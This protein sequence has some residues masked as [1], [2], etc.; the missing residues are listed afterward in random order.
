M[1]H[2]S[3]ADIKSTIVSKMA[4]ISGRATPRNLQRV[5]VLQ[6][7]IRNERAKTWDQI[8]KIWFDETKAI[9]KS[10]PITMQ[11]TMKTVVPTKVEVA[12]P[13]VSQ[14][15]TL[16]TH[17]PFQGRVLKQWADGIRKKD[18][19]RIHDQITI[20][21]TQG[22]SNVAIA[23]RVVGTVGLRGANGVTQITRNDALAITRT[24]V[25]SFA[26][27][28]R[29]LFFEANKDA[30]KKERYVATLDNRTTAI[31][32]SLD[33]TV[34]NV[35]DGP[36]PPLHFQCRSIRVAILDKGFVSFRP[37]KPT[38]ERELVGKFAARNNLGIIT[39]RS[40]LPYGYKGRYDSFAKTEI[41]KLTGTV[42]AK[43]T[44]GSWLAKQSKV[45]Q[46][47]VLGVTKARLFRDGHLSLDKYVDR[48]GNE[49]TLS[50]LA[51]KEAQAFKAAGLDP[52]EFY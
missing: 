4:L 2:K 34:Y 27:R 42:P 33:G 13:A 5:A 49:L 37:A 24:A 23:R 12:L 11:K 10:E 41:R 9:A 21:I 52:R 17:H 46:E 8:N 16:V 32:R 45:F 28:S 51:H 44:Y 39:K 43:T 30:F 3:D 35:G 38:T 25:L 31:C 19:Q 14:L 7:I 40:G 26:N 47:D 50:Q 15:A 1:L 29:Q 48:A 6:R 22:E 18:I 20:G 36:Y